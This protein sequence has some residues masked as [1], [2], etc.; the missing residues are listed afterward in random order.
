MPSGTRGLL[1]GALAIYFT[2][3]TLSSALVA[4]WCVGRKV[5]TDG[6]VFQVRDDEPEPRIGAAFHR[7]P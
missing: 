1:N 7:T 2:D 3:A 6:G 4:W 5:E